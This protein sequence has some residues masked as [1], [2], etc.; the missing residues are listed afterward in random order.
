MSSVSEALIK[1]IRELQGLPSLQHFSL[2]GGTNLAL[3]YHHRQSID[4]DL[5][6]PDIIGK[7]GYGRIVKEIKERFGND[8]FGCDYP[9]DIDDQYL[10]LRLFIRKE[11]IGIK[12]EILQNFKTLDDPER[13]DGIRLLSEKD[14]GLF[15]LMSAS[16][17]AS[18]KDIYDL[19]FITR[20]I[21]LADLLELLRLK[22]EKFNEEIHQTIFDLDREKSPV[23]FP[24]LL[25]KFDEASRPKAARPSHSNDRIDVMPDQKNWQVAR[26]NWRRKVRRLYQ[27]LGLEF[28]SVQG[29]DIGGAC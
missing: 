4:I 9:C 27:H 17:R 28:P 21:P 29:S 7:E 12:V 5:F 26:S 24:E 13:L 23:E 11:D 22:Q 1:T 19:D 18:N 20:K 8:I 10:F 16:N 2:G 3:R 15:K 6:C 14:I 25:L